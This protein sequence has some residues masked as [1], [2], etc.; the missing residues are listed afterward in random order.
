MKKKLR[1]YRVSPFSRKQ[2]DKIVASI[3]KHRFD[4]QKAT[5]YLYEIE[6]E[7]D[8]EAR[9]I[10]KLE[11]QREVI[12][13][14]GE[15]ISTT[16]ISFSETNFRLSNEWPY[17]EISSGFRG[18][19]KL[20]NHLAMAVNFEIAIEE[21]TFHVKKFIT[22]MTRRVEHPRV[23]ALTIR[24]LQVDSTTSAHLEVSSTENALD[25]IS[26]LLGTKKFTLHKARIEWIE[27]GV[28]AFVFISSDGHLAFGTTKPEQIVEVASIARKG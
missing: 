21:E 16:F 2:F 23:V 20:L 19:T 7:G 25:K 11:V 10:E 22:T 13:P 8:F 26:P 18:A 15:A 28:P 27:D 9:F 6:Q 5:G 14:L 4:G 12:S 24:N 1:W 17:L 3:K